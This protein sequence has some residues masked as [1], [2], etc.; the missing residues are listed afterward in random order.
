MSA[1]LIKR[2]RRNNLERL[3]KITV[4]VIISENYLIYCWKWLN[5]LGSKVAVR[6]RKDRRVRSEE[7]TD[8]QGYKPLDEGNRIQRRTSFISTFTGS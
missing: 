2:F 3:R 1:R 7:K 4:L 8:R 6:K 5:Y